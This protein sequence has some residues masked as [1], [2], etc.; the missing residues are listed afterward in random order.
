MSHLVEGWNI[1]ALGSKEGACSVIWSH[2]VLG[3]HRGARGKTKFEDSAVHVCS[4][5]EG[6]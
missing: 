3:L 1:F 4:S 6:H 5:D 2:L